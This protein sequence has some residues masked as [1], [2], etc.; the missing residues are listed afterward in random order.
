MFG[1]TYHV[2][3]ILPQFLHQLHVAGCVSWIYGILVLCP[4]HYLAQT[5]HPHCQP[6]VHVTNKS[7]CQSINQSISH[8]VGKTVSQ[9]DKEKNNQ[10]TNN[11][12]L[13]NNPGNN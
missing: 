10:S 9:Y 4:V 7:Q 13:S 5:H 3:K 11:E 8:T 2:I 12:T 1:K 6:S